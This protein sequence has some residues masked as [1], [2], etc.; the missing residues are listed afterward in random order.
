MASVVISS[1]VK[2]NGTPVSARFT[3]ITLEDPHYPVEVSGHVALDRP[4]TLTFR[5]RG[6]NKEKVAGLAAIAASFVAREPRRTLAGYVDAVCNVGTELCKV[7]FDDSSQ[8]IW[9]FITLEAS[10]TGADET[11]ML[12]VHPVD[13]LRFVASSDYHEPDAA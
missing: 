4:V 7:V 1:D 3:S 10:V 5:S 11:V 8:T 6:M 13:R 12:T 9:G 2:V